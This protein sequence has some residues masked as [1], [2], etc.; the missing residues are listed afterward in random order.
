MTVADP[1]LWIT[2]A[3]VLDVFAWLRSDIRELRTDMQE[4][5]ERMDR[6]DERLHGVA[7]DLAE[8]KG[9]LSFIETYILRRN[10][11]AP[12]PAE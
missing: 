8:M 2:P 10:E 12:D 11:P 3:V 5:R 1:A 4:L 9:K 6:F 7:Q